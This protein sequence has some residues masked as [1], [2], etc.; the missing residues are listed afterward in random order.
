M[1]LLPDSGMH[2]L[3]VASQLYAEDQSDSEWN[4]EDQSDSEWNPED[5]SEGLMYRYFAR[6]LR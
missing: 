3:V 6:T 5:Q 1:A 2:V 4:P